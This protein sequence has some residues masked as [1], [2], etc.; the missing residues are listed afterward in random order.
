MTIE[1]KIKAMLIDNMVPEAMA[2][3]I[4][5]LLKEAEGDTMSRHW[6]RDISEYPTP[7]IAT[8]W[9]SAKRIALEYIDAHLP[10]AW[11]R[12]LLAD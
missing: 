4:V 5:K 8:L 11:F 10:L 7:M 2:D 6:R 1:E 3:E 9:A 12:P